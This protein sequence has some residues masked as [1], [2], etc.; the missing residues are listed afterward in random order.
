MKRMRKILF[1]AMAMVVPVL[2][3][4]CAPAL[5]ESTGHSS[6]Q[7]LADKRIGVQTGSTFDA[8][9]RESLPNAKIEYYNTYADMVEALMSNKIDGFP[10]DEPVIQMIQAEN[11]RIKIV[12]ER[13]NEF[14]FG[15]VFPKSSKGEAL[16]KELDE[17]IAQLKGSGELDNMT[18]KWTRGSEDEKTIP[19]YRSLPAPKGTLVM[20]CEG[21]YPPMNYYH[22]NEAVGMEVE[23]AARFCEDKGY[24]LKIDVTN[25]DGVLPA[26]QTGKADFAM[27][28]ITIT[29]ERK[30]SVAFS[31][32]YYVG[33]TVMAVLGDEAAGGSGGS[34]FLGGIAESF[35]K[36]FV[37]ENR[38][39]M[40]LEGVGTTLA[41]TLLSIILGTALGFVVFVL[42]RNGGRIANGI[43]GACMWLLQGMPGVVLLMILYYVVFGSFSI[44]GVAVSVVAFTLTFGTSVFGLLKT[45]VGAVDVGQG[46][47]A[48]A[49]GYHER[50]TFYKIILPQALPHV[51]GPFRG[52]VVN[53]IKATSIVGYIAVQ[54]L[55]KMGDIIR[56]RTYEAFFPLIAITIIYFALEGLL[57]L[58]VSRIRVS[59]D[60][61]R[62]TKDDILKGVKTDD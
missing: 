60:P 16:K 37:R 47:A 33:G 31:D 12:D 46:E 32:P 23:L 19:D 24:G 15:A 26:V 55:T 6:L 7:E 56:S 62:R 25:F 18:N 5:A 9:T 58:I 44:G 8:I 39:Q 22:N 10:G 53:L 35:E 21:Q 17:F 4:V 3:V 28:G 45:G 1:A 27:S 59:I 54:D 52:E 36:T 50:Q 51:I 38:W 48:A 2:L 57:G 34:G 30:E 29:D 20:A 61:K 40:L 43:T 42:C 41:I 11:P 13:M 14:E 49:L